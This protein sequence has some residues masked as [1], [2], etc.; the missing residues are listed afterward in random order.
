MKKK[1]I[2]WKL[3]SGRRCES[4]LT[5]RFGKNIPNYRRLIE[6]KSEFKIKRYGTYRAGVVALGYSQTPGVD[7]TKNFASLAQDESFRIALAR[8]MVEMLVSLVMDVETAFLYGEIDEEIFMKITS[9]NGR[10]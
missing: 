2:I 5:E 10:K 1:E 6:N 4:L 7:Y 9:W 8:I 3:P